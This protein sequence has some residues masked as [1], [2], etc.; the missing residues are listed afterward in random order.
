MNKKAHTE[1]QILEALIAAGG[2]QS[3]AA[4]ILKC[5]TGKIS[6]YVTKSKK[7]QKHLKQIREEILDI[8]ET[9][10]IKALKAEEAWAIKYYLNCKGKERG[11]GIQA[12]ITGKDGGPLDCTFRWEGEGADYHAPVSAP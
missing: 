2:I 7:L 6:G 12:I 5:S 4:K 11:Y 3:H 10:L 1:A 8:A 9:A